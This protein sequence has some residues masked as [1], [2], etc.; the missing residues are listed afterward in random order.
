MNEPQTIADR[1]PL[2]PTEAPDRSARP[3][4]AKVKPRP[5]QALLLIWLVASLA[6]FWVA[7][8][9]DMKAASLG[10]QRD[11]NGLKSELTRNADLNDAILKGLAAALDAVSWEG[12]GS[13]ARIYARKILEEYPHVHL[14]GVAQRVEGPERAVF[15]ARM[16]ANGWPDFQMRRF[17]YD[18]ERQWQPVPEKA[19]HYPAVMVEP[20]RQDTLPLIGLD[21]DA[22]PQMRHALLHS[23]QR[24]GPTPSDAFHFT[25]GDLGYVVVYPLCPGGRAGNCELYGTSREP[26]LVAVLGVLAERLVGEEDAA[27]RSP[28]LSYTVYRDWGARDTD[29]ALLSRDGF[30]TLLERRLLPRLEREFRAGAATSQPFRVA[31]SEQMTFAS[32]N[33]WPYLGVLMASLAGLA[34]LL[35]L[36]QLQER[37]GSA[38]AAALQRSR[39]H[40]LQ[41]QERVHIRTQAL[42]WANEDLHEQ[43]EARLVAEE[44]LRLKNEQMKRLARGMLEAQ[45]KERRALALELHDGISQALTAI[46]VYAKLIAQE[47]NGSDDTTG[48]H[49]GLIM[50][51]AGTIYDD[52]HM[53]M[54]RLRPR[55]LDDLGLVAS[56][57]ACAQ[58]VG[59][60]AQ[61]IT[62]HLHIDPD[63]NAL[64]GAAA[65]TLYRLLQEALTNV[66]MHSQAHNVWVRAEWQ[67]DASG[68][69][70]DAP[71]VTLNVE[72]DGCGLP[73]SDVG[74]SGL[75]LVGARERV[76]ALGGDFEVTTS[77][78]G[79]VRLRATLPIG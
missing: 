42:S 56:L 50:D 33:A 40:Q 16:R 1:D 15:E 28:A 18:I 74:S 32:L 27:V 52:T 46:R 43:I 25:G 78:A 29:S 23:L 39:E 2:E 12:L 30:A 17:D 26:E 54:R 75:G 9:L 73:E 70:G 58:Q 62:V 76:T 77:D 38:E 47:H 51:M 60:D 44:R 19:V 35:R 61:G 41:L 79:G 5:W 34:L 3:A 55:A 22:V 37:I 71:L 66:S 36:R 7:V 72:D 48:R 10:L 69:F 45:E 57:E 68:Q 4:L 59:L 11:V 31:V 6:G 65:I 64:E 24:Q 21:M 63:L 53:M 8:Y 13:G 49:A 67:V 20:E 14:V